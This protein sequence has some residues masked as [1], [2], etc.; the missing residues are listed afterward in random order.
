MTI[1]QLFARPRPVASSKNGV[2]VFCPLP[3]TPNRVPSARGS[4]MISARVRD[5][6]HW[7]GHGRARY[8]IREHLVHNLLDGQTC[9]A[10]PRPARPG[11]CAPVIFFVGELVVTALPW[12][13]DVAPA[14]TRTHGGGRYNH[15]GSPRPQPQSARLSMQCRAS[16]LRS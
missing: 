8:A 1:H 7:A 4:S 15:T 13:C 10:M 9:G 14:L 6:G 2:C 11:I 12:Q 16:A 3:K 5:L